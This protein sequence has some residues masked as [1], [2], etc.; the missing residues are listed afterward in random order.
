MG[1]S[2]DTYEAGSV[3]CSQTEKYVPYTDCALTSKDIHVICS[4]R[5]LLPNPSMIC[6]TAVSLN[7]HR[8]ITNRCGAASY[9]V[10]QSI[11]DENSKTYE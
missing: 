2:S 3:A 5:V 4:V 7:E 11:A 6:W 1:D 8:H 9:T 10:E